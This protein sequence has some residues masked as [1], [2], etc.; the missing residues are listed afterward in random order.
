MK[1]LADNIRESITNDTK[2]P[3][4]ISRNLLSL[5][6]SLD[7][8]GKEIIDNY[9]NQVSGKTFSALKEKSLL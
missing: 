5:W 9:Q 3:I 4:L 8:K 7:N 6:N 1:T 2:S